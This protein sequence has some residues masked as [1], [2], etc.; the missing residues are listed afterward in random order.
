MPKVYLVQLTHVVTSD[1][2]H[3]VGWCAAYDVMERFSTRTS[4]RYGNSPNQ[5]SN[6]NI[7]VLAS[8]FSASFDDVQNAESILKSKYPKNIWINDTFAGITEIVRL[9]PDQRQDTIKYIRSLHTKWNQV[10]P[11]KV[12]DQYS[13]VLIN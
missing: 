8:A 9:D 12:P 7:R 13:D 10:T 2:F 3:K 5:Y 4:E 11:P 6:Y 1:T